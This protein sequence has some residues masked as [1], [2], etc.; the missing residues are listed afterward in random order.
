MRLWKLL[1]KD[2]SRVS[3]RKV[4]KMKRISA[5]PEL[6]KGEQLTQVDSSSSSHIVSQI[7]RVFSPLRRD[8]DISVGN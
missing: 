4:A 2:R 6:R 7:P 5:V 1:P 8:A 3:I